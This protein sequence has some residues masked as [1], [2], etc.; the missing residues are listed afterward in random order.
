LE[1]LFK[2]VENIKSKLNQWGK[3]HIPFVFLIDF[4][5]KK[6]LCWTW[7]EAA[8]QFTF[9]FDGI[10]NQ[11][12]HSIQKTET[13]I[14]FEKIPISFEQYKNKFDQVKKEIGLG[15]SFLINLTTATKIETNFTL[16]QIYS[17]A[18]AKYIC[19]LKN[20][21]VCFSPETFI[22]I[23]EN[24][25][26]SYP[27]KGTIQAGI[28]NA[29][30]IILNDQKEFAEHATMVDLIRNDLSKVANNVKVNQFRYYEEI[31]TNN[32][33]LGQVSSEI[34]GELPPLFN[35]KI[36]DILFDLIPAGSIS[37]APKQKTLEIISKVEKEDRGYYTGIAGYFDGKNLDSTVLIRFLQNDKTY[38]SGGG[39]TFNSDAMNEYNEMINKVYVPFF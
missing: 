27:M 38:R 23:K 6:P 8:T 25:I 35:E 3:K 16:D 21:F 39:I 30:N 33:N 17:N 1:K 28:P 15:N 12:N 4:E 13:P 14:H 24:K 22:K 32:G 37:G 9:N 5:C 18:H 31:K 11:K 7:E 29:K 10:T 26:Y 36:G 2:E 19:C 20:E 34:V